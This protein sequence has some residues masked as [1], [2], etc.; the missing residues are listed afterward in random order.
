M[1]FCAECGAADQN[2]KFCANCGSST[3]NAPKS[4]ADK[5]ETA[6]KPD[7]NHYVLDDSVLASY[8][9]Q[10]EVQKNQTRRNAVIAVLVVVVLVG[11]VLFA[12]NQRSSS[13]SSSSSDVVDSSAS[14]TSSTSDSIAPAE[15]APVVDT[16]AAEAAMTAAVESTWALSSGTCV[17]NFDPY[18]M[19][20]TFWERWDGKVGIVSLMRKD[21]NSAWAGVTFRVTD[22]GSK[23]SIVQSQD[24]PLAND[25]FAFTGTPSYTCEPWTVKK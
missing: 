19:L 23:W 21:D 2:G 7:Q 13:P 20:Y 17:T 8:A 14:D 18:E 15:D 4:E 1:A 6:A 12:L 5:K 24:S 9:A 11:G 22:K 10:D 16:S 3:K 25:K